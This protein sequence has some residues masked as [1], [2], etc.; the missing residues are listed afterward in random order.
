MSQDLD[1]LD[2][3]QSTQEAWKKIPFE[4]FPC[5]NEVIDVLNAFNAFGHKKLAPCTYRT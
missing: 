4:D 2:A 5:E 1:M 3:D